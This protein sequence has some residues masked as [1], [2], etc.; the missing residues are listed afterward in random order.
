MKANKNVAFHKHCFSTNQ[1]KHQDQRSRFLVLTK[2]SAASGDENG[3]LGEQIV[4]SVLLHTMPPDSP[5]KSSKE[6][7]VEM[8]PAPGERL[9]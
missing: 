9:P 8:H 6:I 5:T 3:L 2:R 1:R 7:H 4:F